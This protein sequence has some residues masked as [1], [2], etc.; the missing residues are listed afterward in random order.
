MIVLIALLL[1]YVGGVAAGIYSHSRKNDQLQSEVDDLKRRVRELEVTTQKET[2]YV[3]YSS[4]CEPI[5]PLYDKY[6]VTCVNTN[7]DA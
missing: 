6:K 1:V 4:P 3:P 2:I 7:N 5:T